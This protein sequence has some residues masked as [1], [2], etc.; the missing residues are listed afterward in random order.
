MEGNWN[1]AAGS[2]KY[3]YNG[4]EWNDDFGLGWNLY[5]ARP[6]DPATGRFTGIDLLAN[7]YN[8][9]TP[10][11]YASNSP[12]TFIDFLGLGAS[13]TCL[14]DPELE[15]NLNQ[16]EA[17]GRDEVHKRSEDA[18]E[19][20]PVSYLE[21]NSDETICIPCLVAR[22]VAA[23]AA[24]EYGSQVVINLNEGKGSKSFTDIKWNDVGKAA[25]ISGGIA[26]V[27]SKLTS[28]P[29]L[30]S[31]I[32]PGAAPINGIIK[33]LSKTISVQ[34]QARHIAGT[35]KPGAGYLNS[36]DDAQEILDAV[37][38]GKAIFLGT[39]KAGHQVYKYTGVTGTNV[40]LGAKISGQQTNVFMIKGTTSP[41]VVPTNPF[42]KL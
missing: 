15:D 18:T 17:L 39:S 9:Q 5:E 3:Q 24:F 33:G 30:L 42:W 16:S 28:I 11:A 4:K 27:A 26:T 10:Y 6:Y 8:T 20:F 21:N 34:K 40:N 1:G 22:S 25:I 14:L 35:A 29:K 12:A 37:H 41:S 38:S 13:S 7:I 36:L 2:N 23:G 31:R 32:G 19:R